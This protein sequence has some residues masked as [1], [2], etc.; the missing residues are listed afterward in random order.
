VK[1]SNM[2]LYGFDCD[3]VVV[4]ASAIKFWEN[5]YPHSAMV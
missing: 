3:A 2:K 4:M 1:S 5:H